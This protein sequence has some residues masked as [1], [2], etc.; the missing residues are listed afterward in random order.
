[1][2]TRGTKEERGRHCHVG[3]S[4]LRERGEKGRGERAGGGDFPNPFSKRVLGKTIKDINK[5]SKSQ[6]YYAPA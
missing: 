6:K 1:V 3:P 2:A 4:C 5:N